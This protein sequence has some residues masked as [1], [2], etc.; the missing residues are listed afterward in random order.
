MYRATILSDAGASGRSID[1]IGIVAG[2]YTLAGNAVHASVWAFGKQI[3][4]GTLGSPALSSKVLWPDGAHDQELEVV[5]TK[6]GAIPHH[7][8]GTRN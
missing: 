5:E 6:R 1:D 8:C 7:S 2:S 4:L 3:E